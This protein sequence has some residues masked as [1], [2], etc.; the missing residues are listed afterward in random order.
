MNQLHIYPTSRALRNVSE[1]YA[2][3]E[4]FIPSLMRIDEF[5][6]RAILL[7]ELTP[8]DPLERILLLR[9][10]TA[11]EGFEALKFDRSLVKF[12]TKSEAIFKFFEE[13]HAEGVSFESLMQADAYA[14]FTEHIAILQE[15]FY[16]Y[17]A[18]L[19]K[20]G[21]TDKMLLP[22]QYRL[23]EGF[24]ARYSRIEIF[25]EGYVSEF[26]LSL[27]EAIAEITPL[28]IH[29]HTSSFNQKMQE[30]FLSRGI[31]LPNNSEVSFLLGERR[32]LQ[33]HQQTKP[34]HAEVYS[35]EERNG[36]IAGAFVA[37]ES[38]VQ[39]GIA[40]EKIALVLPDESMKAHFKLFDKEGNLNFSMG[41]DYADERVYKQLE[42]LLAYW[43]SFDVQE[44]RLLERYGISLEQ[45]DDGLSPSSTMGVEAFFSLLKELKLHEGVASLEEVASEEM[46][47][48][49]ESLR[50]LRLFEKY[51]FPA[52][53]WLFLWLKLLSTITIDDVRGGLITVMGLLET[54]GV[55]FDGVVVVDFNEG[56]VPASSSKDQFLNTSVRAFAKL[57]TREDREALQKQYYKRLFEEA[58]E[59]AIFYSSASN[60]LPS[61]FL[62]EL[63]L[64]EGR[65]EG[66]P[67]GLLY[68]Q[69][70]RIVP[71]K[72][73]IVEQFDAKATVWSASRL[74]CFLSCKRKY[75]YRYYANIPQKKEESLNEGAFLHTLLFH[76]FEERDSYTSTSQMQEALAQLID[77]KHP[78]DDAKAS[79]EKR[80]WRAKLKPFIAQQV[81][82][83]QEGWRVVVREEEFT[84]NIG[85]LAFKGRIDRID[86]RGD[87]ALVLDYKSGNVPKEPKTLNPEKIVDFQMP[88][89]AHLVAQRFT[90]TQ[91]A[92]L[93]L[94]SQEPLQYVGHLAQR[95]ELLFEKIVEL[96]QTHAFEAQ[97]CESMQVCQWC[98]YRLLCERGEFL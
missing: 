94:F 62:Y 58:K 31:A 5:E 14:E 87:E 59:V 15:L 84:A 2:S 78:Y 32:I 30:R 19:A 23:N 69:K 42:A 7:D 48:Y 70:S 11:F 80:L 1:Y 16:A 41:F 86:Q 98:E 71:L 67:L 52:K 96:K 44:R 17:E 89:Y 51:Q 64:K 90:Q 3:I 57:P 76:L 82:H 83:F 39:R 6:K 26:E 88:L 4:G 38:M 92:Y 9:E 72:D 93:K 46:V 36:Q 21:Y 45:L 95:E 54:R 75:Y 8:I 97:K 47:V 40:P 18:L 49:E 20:R 12:F 28:V 85:G 55:Q 65:E 50:F 60:R 22:K 29:Y 66:V 81:A 10:A 35:I 61:K 27:F 79:Y 24:L 77:I 68:D 25:L 91:L 33:S 73:P 37:I 56:V 63:G 13:I 74:S 34:I 53:Q 43:S